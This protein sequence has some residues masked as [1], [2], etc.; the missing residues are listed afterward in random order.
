ML[1]SYDSVVLENK[2]LKEY[3]V[4][5]KKRYQQYQH[6]QQQEQY[7]GDREYFERKPQKKH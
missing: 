1:K 7:S 4:N 2:Q 3:I 6:L 5:I